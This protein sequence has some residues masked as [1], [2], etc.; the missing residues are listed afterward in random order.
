MVRLTIRCIDKNVL[1]T[2]TKKRERVAIGPSLKKVTTAQ[3]TMCM[4]VCVCVWG[5][6]GPYCS[7]A[8]IIAERKAQ[9]KALMGDSTINWHLP[10]CLA[11]SGWSEYLP[12]SVLRPYL[13]V[14]RSCRCWDIGTGKQT[15]HVC[16]YC[17]I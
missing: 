8:T 9:Q 12:R 17:E 16:E 14:S 15:K 10:E 2:L 11:L 13:I 7:V 4:Y 3:E 6:P 5:G 1:D